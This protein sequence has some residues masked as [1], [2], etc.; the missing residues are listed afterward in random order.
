[1]RLSLMEAAHADVGGAP[2][3]E[4]RVAHLF[5]PMYAGTNMGHPSQGPAWIVFIWF[6]F[7]TDFFG[8]GAVVSHISRKTSEIWGTRRSAAGMNL[9]IVICGLVF[10]DFGEDVQR[11]VYLGGVQ[12]EEVCQEWVDVYVFEGG[13]SRT[14]PDVGAHGQ[15][16]GPHGLN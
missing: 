10:Q 3:Q 11:A 14:G 7:G 2:W 6:C 15:E 8:F 13:E 1:M 4:I 5:R 12:A 16:V 9:G